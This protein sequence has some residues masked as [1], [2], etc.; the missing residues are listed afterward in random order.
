[1]EKKEKL[2]KWGRPRIEIVRGDLTLPSEVYNLRTKGW[3]WKNIAIS[4]GL[5]ITTTRRL[6]QRAIKEGEEFHDKNPY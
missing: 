2:K 3:S 4:L 1:M 5:A 6:Y